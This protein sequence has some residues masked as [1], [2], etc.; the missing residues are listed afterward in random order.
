[1]ENRKNTLGINRKTMLVFHRIMLVA[2]LHNSF[3][4]PCQSMIQAQYGSHEL[5]YNYFT[6]NN[7]NSPLVNSTSKANKTVALPN[8]IAKNAFRTL[9]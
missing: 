5:N 8:S 7:Y 3:L 4:A 9:F 1:M 6:S 2:I